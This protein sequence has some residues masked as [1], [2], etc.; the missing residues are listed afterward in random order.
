MYSKGE[1]INII[2]NQHEKHE[3]LIN[4]NHD[5]RIQS[6]KQYI[7]ELCNNTNI[8]ICSRKHFEN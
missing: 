1:Y 4:R 8:R 7:G 5:G 2:E 3:I 6:T